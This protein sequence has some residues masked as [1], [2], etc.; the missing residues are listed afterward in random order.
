MAATTRRAALALPLL[1]IFGLGAWQAGAEPEP[2][3]PAADP[4]EVF[5]T[6]HITPESLV[7]IYE[8]LGVEL[9]GRV[10]VKLHSGEPGGKRDHFL[11]SVL[12]E[13]LVHR[14]DGTIVETNAT[15]GGRT[16]TREHTRVMHEHGFAAIAP[17]EILDDKGSL[18]LPVQGGRN[19]EVNYVGA[20][21]ADYDSFMILS[22]FKG[23]AMAGYGGAIKNMAIGFATPEGKYWLHS[24]GK[25]RRAGLVPALRAFVFAGQARFLES[26]AEA[27]SSI[28]DAVDRAGGQIVYINVMNNLSVDCDCVPNPA[29]PELHDLGVLASLDPVALDR[30]CLDK[31]YEVQDETADALKERIES[32]DGFHTLEHAESIGLGSQV[33]ELIT[34]H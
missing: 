27:A 12:I 10:A 23:H 11:S 28:V 9:E 18:E 16:H 15:F 2:T 21:F 25:T 32:R 22:H 4:P 13:N 30:A 29:A 34:L 3:V 1:A 19:L 31:V 14:V 17:F 33:Y 26:L 6:P 20:G 5:F 7:E 24:G 8:A